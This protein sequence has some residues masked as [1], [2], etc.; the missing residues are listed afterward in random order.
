MCAKWFPFSYSYGEELTR[1]ETATAGVSAGFRMGAILSNKLQIR[2]DQQIT[3]YTRQTHG[4]I[5]RRLLAQL[6]MDIDSVFKKTTIG[7]PR[8]VMLHL[9]IDASSSMSGPKWEKVMSVATAIAFTATKIKNLDAVISLR[10]TT[11][12]RLPLVAVIFDSRNDG[13]A[14]IRAL[15][16]LLTPYGSTP[17]GLCFASTMDLITECAPTHITYFIN[18]SDGEPMCGFSHNGRWTDYGGPNA[19]EQTKNAVTK[20][21]QAGV[22]VMSYF[23]EGTVS[24]RSDRARRM[25]NDMYGLDAE[26]VD[27]RNVTQVVRTLNKLLITES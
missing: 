1:V 4:K 27:V 9:S 15:F 23:I 7:E 22:K 25:F 5:D 6:G 11:E 10:G 18:Y 8:P 2:N 16:P 24:V 14:K 26:Y 17:E 19:T 12:S 13:I 20:I 3:H 21:R